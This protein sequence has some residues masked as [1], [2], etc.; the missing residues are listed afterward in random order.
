[1]ENGN[2]VLQITQHEQD[3]QQQNEIGEQQRIRMGKLSELQSSGS[4][5]YRH[6]KLDITAYAADIHGD[7]ASHEGKIY[8]L[9]GRIMQKRGMGKACFMDILD[10][11]GRIQLYCKSDNITTP[12]YEQVLKL[13]I[14]DIIGVVGEVF[15][16]HKGEISVSVTEL[17]LLCKSL[18]PLPEKYHGLRDTD[19]RYRQRYLDLIMNP[20][21]RDTFVKRSRIISELRRWLD[22]K[23]FIEVETPLL[24]TI[25]SGAAARPFITH[26]NTLDI[27]M[28]LRIAMELH[29]KRLIVGGLDKVYEI[30]RIFRNEGMDPRH[31]PEFTMM[32]LYQAYTDY[33]GIM[34]LVE[35][36]VTHLCD[37]ILGTRVL[38]YNGRE[39]NFNTP[40]ERIDM[41]EAVERITGIN[42]YDIET[43]DEARR[44]TRDLGVEVKSTD[45]WGH[46][47]NNAFETL[48]EPTLWQPAFVMHQP[49]DVSPLA[50]RCPTNPRITERFEPFAAGMEFGNAFS[51]LN[52]PIDQRQRFVQQALA[53]A[54]GD[55]EAPP[56]DEDFLTAIEYGM[57]PTGGLGIGID[58]LVMLLCDLST[59]RDSLLFPTMKP[60]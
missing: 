19:T 59:I 51:E 3:V 15:T 26:H 5:P 35:D 1:M 10:S 52:D 28:R 8:T 54:A 38:T 29:H 24:T 60:V 50:K 11:T 56:S 37:T 40:W 14:G 21:V 41:C 9:A 57:P 31:N 33:N 39:L 43:D 16:T 2:D 20:D 27:D 7:Y 36:M 22:A 13:D 48:V 58:R 42:Y 46:C 44:I 17:T 55:E 25:A 53:N 45:K 47:L 30:G 49:V 32:E 34:Q 23:G 12:A 4:D 6:T 18:L